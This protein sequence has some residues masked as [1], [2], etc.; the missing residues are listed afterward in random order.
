MRY[1]LQALFVLALALL[2]AAAGGAR[3]DTYST[4][5]KRRYYSADRRYFVEVDEKKRAALYMNGARPLRGWKRM[6][7]ELPGWLVVSNDGTR[8]AVID[9]YYGNGGDPSTTVV[10]ILDESG[11]DLARYSMREV[12]ELSRVSE[13]TSGT[14]WYGGASFTADGR[15]LVVETVVKTCERPPNVTSDADLALADKCDRLMPYERLRF[16]AGTGKLID[17]SF[18]K[19]TDE[20]GG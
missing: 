7:E 4:F 6:L 16:D 10:L 1:R 14:H 5:T 8:A 3:A 18:L 9:R 12:A 2:A 13:T 19:H 11:R 15:F 20:S 17:R